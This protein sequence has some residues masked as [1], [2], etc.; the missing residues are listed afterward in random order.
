MLQKRRSRRERFVLFEGGEKKIHWFID[1]AEKNLKL[2]NVN[3]NDHLWFL[4]SEEV[5]QNDYMIIFE[6]RKTVR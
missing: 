6:E 5:I 3:L 1:R 2:K 4:L